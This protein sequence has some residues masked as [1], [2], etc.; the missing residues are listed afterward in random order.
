MQLIEQH[1]PVPF[2]EF[3]IPSLVQLMRLDEFQLAQDALVRWTWTFYRM[4]IE[5]SCAIEMLLLCCRNDSY[6]EKQS[7]KTEGVEISFF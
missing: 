7:P 5:Q 1:H 4:T 2:E 6:T 3:V